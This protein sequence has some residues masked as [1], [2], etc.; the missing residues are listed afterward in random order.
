MQVTKQVAYFAALT[1]AVLRLT[2]RI[3][4]CPEK[5][6]V[7]RFIRQNCAPSEIK[8]NTGSGA[9]G[10]WVAGWIWLV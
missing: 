5:G 7:L 6:C 10:C 9:S 2:A 1:A 8:V 3:S 4:S